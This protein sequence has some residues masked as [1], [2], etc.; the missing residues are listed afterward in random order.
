M[1]CVGFSATGPCS[2]TVRYKVATGPGRRFACGRHI[3]WLLGRVLAEGETA[4]VTR[5]KD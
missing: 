1:S 3:G 4:K 5:V 2:A